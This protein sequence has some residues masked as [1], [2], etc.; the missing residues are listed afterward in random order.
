MSRLFSNPR[1]QFYKEDGVTVNTAGKIYF[2]EPGVGS[3]T[4]KSV[5]SDYLLTKALTNPVILSATGQLESDIWLNGDYKWKI[6]NSLGVTLSTGN[7]Y[8]PADLSAQFSDWDATITYSIYD[9][10]RGS[11]GSYYQSLA[12]GNV[13]NNPVGNTTYWVKAFVTPFALWDSAYIYSVD[14]FTRG[15]DGNY[16]QSLTASNLN[17]NPTSSA[18]NW[19]QIYFIDV[20]NTNKTYATNDIVKYQDDLWVA[21]SGQSG[22]TPSVSSSYWRSFFS[23]RSYSNFTGTR[24]QYLQDATTGF[25]VAATVSESAA[26][27]S[28]V[29]PTGSGADHIWTAM[30]DITTDA[31]AVSLKCTALF[32]RTSGADSDLTGQV[33]AVDGDS[34]NIPNGASRVIYCSAHGGTTIPAIASAVNDFNIILDSSRRFKIAWDGTNQTSAA[35][36]LNLMGYLV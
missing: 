33:W 1:P 32:S 19:V 9:Y 34:T 36:G 35:I 21:L 13:G 7:N 2:Y 5:Y 4:L 31:L 8:E 22:N 29:G 25:D 27:F 11:N 28:T 3:T 12:S 6:T 20:W 16:Y 17:N 24:Y 18:A 15:S 14:D 30:N 10:V 26:S 23:P